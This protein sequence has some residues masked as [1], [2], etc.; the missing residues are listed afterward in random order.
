M[1]NFIYDIPTKVFFG[2]GQ[3]EQLPKLV[4]KFGKRVLL[5]YGGGSIKRNGLYDKVKELLSDCEIFELSG[6]DPNPRIESVREGAALCKEHKID[7]VLAVGGGS[8]IDC[9]KVIAAA[10]KYDG[11]AWDLVEN[12][13]LIEAALPLIDILTLS[14]T[15]TEMNTGAVITNFATKDKSGT[16]AYVMYPYASICDPTYTFTVPHNQTAAGTADIMSHTFE[17]YFN[18]E[19]GVFVQDRM[20]EGILEACIH[21]LPIALKEPDNY[22]ARANLMWASTLA[23]NGL[24]RM[25]RNGAW[26]CHPIEHMLSAYYDITHAVGLA[27]LTPRW[28]AYCLNEDTVERFAMYA[29]RVWKIA[30]Q[31][32]L[33][34]MAKEAIEKTYQFFVDADMPMTLP[35]VEIDAEHFD[36]MAERVAPRLT[37]SYVPLDKDAVVAI[38]E[39]CMTPGVTYR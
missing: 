23:L 1:Q 3:I 7:V 35:E 15:G 29:N 2:E 38:L 31:D 25:G 9:S 17:I 16:G 14:A 5:T 8:T 6:I 32:D 27:I 19:P 18:H 22:E 28:M 21:Y 11:D 26:T 30:Y 4:A 33:Y 12:P 10:A 39:D 36:E 13:T 24:T 37:N 20:A 34:A